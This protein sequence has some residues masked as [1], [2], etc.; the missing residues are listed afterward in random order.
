LHGFEELGRFSLDDVQRRRMFESFVVCR[1]H[2]N[3]LCIVGSRSRYFVNYSLLR[4]QGEIRKKRH[5]SKAII[6]AHTRGRTIPNQQDMYESQVVF[7][8]VL[9]DVELSLNQS[10][11]VYL[12]H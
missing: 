6:H 10:V 5:V 4:V 12:Y 7:F 8:Q 3:R 11:V 1:D 9:N 2:R